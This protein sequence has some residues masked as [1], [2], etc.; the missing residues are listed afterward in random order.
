M[1]PEE[2]AKERVKRK[3]KF[4]KKLGE[5]FFTIGI[6]LVIN[7]LTTSFMWSLIP[8]SILILDLIR[9]YFKAFGFPG[10]DP[11]WEYKSYKRELDKIK[12]L[13]DPQP[14]KEDSLDLEELKKKQKRWNEKDLV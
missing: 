9:Q 12:N 11:Y 7:L 4:Y 13:E 5:H 2:I 1:N 6:L 10:Y 3:K 14:N 8:I